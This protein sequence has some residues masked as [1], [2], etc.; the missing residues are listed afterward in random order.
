M[1]VRQ[2]PD[3]RWIAYYQQRGDDGRARVR[4]E[5]FGRGPAG[6]A[7]AYA[8]HKELGLAKRRPAAAASG[9]T[10]L[11]LA[12][13]YHARSGPNKNS[14]KQLWIRLEAHL[15]PA[16]G[17]MA[18]I[19]IRAADVKAYISKREADGVQAATIARELTDLK[20]IM[21]WSVV[22]D[23]PLLPH[24]PIA[25]VKKPRTRTAIARPPTE[26]EAVRILDQ[27]LPHVQRAILLGWFLG[28]RP[29]GEL[30]RLRWSAVSWETGRILVM[31]AH[32]GGPEARSIPIHAELLPRLE[33]WYKDDGKK[34]SGRI[35]HYYGKPVKS[36]G[37]AW[38]AAV[39]A[40]KIGRRV[41]PYDLRHHFVTQAIEEG[42][43]LKTLSEIVGSSPQTL[44]KF[45]QHVTSRQHEKTVSLITGLR[46]GKKNR[47]R[48]IGRH[49][50]RRDRRTTGR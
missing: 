6:E 26:A 48:S 25:H 15:I 13:A 34:D 18:A 11:E 20:A 1:A 10:F 7:R 28:V 24:N 9:P 17:T 5:Y 29:Q 37:V 31:S 2:L 12:I 46:D 3:G 39:K 27:A 41:R 23:P 14:K 19:Q 21:N 36:I 16:F 35:V 32:K 50:P 47:K 33:Q 22:Q 4:K 38:R 45:Y 8:R 43:D 42:A 30:L 44:I 40:A 49:G